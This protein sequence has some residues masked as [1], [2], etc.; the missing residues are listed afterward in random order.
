MTLGSSK[1]RRRQD[2][3][4]RRAEVQGVVRRHGPGALRL[5]V[6]VGLFGALVWG[7]LSLRAWALASPTFQLKDV[8]VS[9]R[10]RATEGE[11][12]R[13]AGLVPGQNLWRLDTAQL[14]RALSAHPWVRH[15]EVTRHF[16]AALS[17]EIEEHRPEA[18]VALGELYVVDEQGVPF[19]RLA[20]ADGLDL[21]LVTGLD[22]DRYLADPGA[23]RARLVEALETMRAYAALRPGL[24]DRLSEV[25]LEPGR[26]L[27]LVTSA[28]QEVRL[29]EGGL[30]QKLARLARVRRELGERGL[31]ADV[32]HLD[33]R[34]RP[35]WVAV[36]LSGAA[37]ER[38]GARTQ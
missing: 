8:R 22:R 32:I 21:P 37:S 15:A 26:A 28:G 12:V 13:L 31:A 7:G 36:K 19:K 30:E 14:E 5:L 4:Q 16:P 10:A 20:A 9:G 11:L 33:N 38:S 3:P 25:R 23:A 17:I 2:A 24:R 1:N 27:A 29:G 35:G 34:A 18:L 6:A